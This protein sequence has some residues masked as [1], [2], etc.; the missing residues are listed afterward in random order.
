MELILG[1]SSSVTPALA[2]ASSNKSIM[3]V[4]EAL[5]TPNP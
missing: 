3:S 4:K 2:R 5:V 1:I